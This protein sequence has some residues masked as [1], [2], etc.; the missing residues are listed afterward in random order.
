MKRKPVFNKI[1]SCGI[2][3]LLFSIL[4]LSGADW[5]RAYIMPS[6]QLIDFMARNFS[7]FMTLIIIQTVSEGNQGKEGDLLKEQVWMKSPDL[8]QSRVLDRPEADPGERFTAY[9]PLLIA[10]KSQRIKAIL[11]GLGIDLE[12]VAFARLDGVIAYRIGRKGPD[13]PKI[14]IEKERF[15]PLLLVYGVTDNLAMRTV[16]VRFSD[17]RKLDQGWYPFEITCTAQGGSE[18]KYHVQTLEVNVPVQNAI[19]DSPGG[20]GTDRSR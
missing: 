18:R 13:S 9:R 5:C 11:S 17:Y 7:K 12:T 4:S 15:L 1:L 2:G 16:T 8:F 19:F 20:R 14:L 6:E 3:L 10:N